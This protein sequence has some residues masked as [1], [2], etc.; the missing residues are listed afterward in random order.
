MN[1]FIISALAFIAIIT[2]VVFVHEYGHYAAARLFG[3]RAHVF[4]VGFGKR[5]FGRRDKNGCDWRVSL[6]PL[7]GYVKFFDDTGAASFNI[8]E[9]Q[10]EATKGQKKYG[11]HNKSL[12]QKSII[13]FAGPLFNI[14]F[15]WF[16][17]S[18]ADYVY[19]TPQMRTVISDLV[20]DGAAIR[21]GLQKGDEFIAINDKK[22][23]NAEEV[24]RIIMTSESRPLRAEVLRKHEKL[25]FNIKPDIVTL[26]A[27][28]RIPQVG[29]YFSEPKPFDSAKSGVLQSLAAGYKQTV[30]LSVA[31]LDFFAKM[32]TGRAS[33]E[34]LSGP[35]RIGKMAGEA[36]QSGL[37]SFIQLTALISVSIGLINLM[38]IPM[39]DGGHLLM[40]GLQAVLRREPGAFFKEWAYKIGFVTVM[41]LM[42][43]ALLND[44]NALNL[45]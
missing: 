41:A 30:F 39:L 9:T 25:I 21:A 24:R 18:A 44:I 29:V 37:R 10:G 11:F 4:S 12:W 28:G 2:L 14:L 33:T 36:A 13:V 1:E 6:L 23:A 27:G 19:G 42:V 3:V 26:D 22:V 38:P 32:F 43:I 34:N 35:V 5:L 31:T 20:K 16:I 8:D 15:S 7:G 45:F 17:F 40:Y